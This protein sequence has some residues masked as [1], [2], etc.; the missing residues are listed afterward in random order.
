MA[1]CQNIPVAIYY[2]KD[3]GLCIGTLRGKLKKPSLVSVDRDKDIVLVS[4]LIG[5]TS[6]NFAKFS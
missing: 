2:W 6:I 1:S 3:Y 5:R 4:V